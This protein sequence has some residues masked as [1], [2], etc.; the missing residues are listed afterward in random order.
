MGLRKRLIVGL[1]AVVVLAVAGGI[2]A[3]VLTTNGDHKSAAKASA[4]ASSFNAAQQTRLERGL[5]APSLRKQASVVAAEIRTQFLAK[6]QPLL[7]AGSRLRVQPATFKV[8]S[9][10]T[11]TVQATVT[12]PR[13]GHWLLLVIKEGAN[14]LLI[15]T[16]RLT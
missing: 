1:I 4:S 15:G 10:W 6:G 13:P 16:R 3:A 7:S 12:G 5:T 8:T 9:P 11:A 2:V 14:W